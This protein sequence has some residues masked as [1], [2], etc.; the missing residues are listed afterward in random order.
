MDSSSQA[1]QLDFTNNA[2]ELFE[3]F[4]GLR[5]RGPFVLNGK[6]ISAYNTRFKSRLD[7]VVKVH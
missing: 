2:D 4:R 6:T 3:A 1:V 5:T 7:N